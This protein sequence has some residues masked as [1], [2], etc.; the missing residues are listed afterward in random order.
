MQIETERLI[1]RPFRESDA[2]DALEYLRNPVPNCFACMKLDSLEEAEA[3][4]RLRSQDSEYCFAIVLKVTG[5][6]IGEID[7]SPE[8]NEPDSE[9]SPIDTFSPCWMLNPA[10]HRKGYAYEA[11]SASSITFSTQPGH[12]ESTLIRRT[13]IIAANTFVKNLACVVKACSSSLFPL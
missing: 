7:A 9:L 10:Y 6:V 11:A 13:L 12:G 5:K 2:A 1:L 3:E 8:R 4:M